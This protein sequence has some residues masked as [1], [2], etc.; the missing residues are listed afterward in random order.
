MIFVFPL[1]A[2]YKFTMGLPATITG[3]DMLL[4]TISEIVIFLSVVFV[5]F[6]CW[7]SDEKNELL[8]VDIVGHGEHAKQSHICFF[9]EFGAEVNDIFDPNTSD[10]EFFD[11]LTSCSDAV[12]IASPDKFHPE[13]LLQLVNVGKHVLV[14]KPI[15]IDAPGKKLVEEAVEIAKQKN[16]VILTCHPRR[17]DPPVGW[18]KN[19]IQQCVVLHGKLVKFTFEF[20][21]HKVTDLWKMDRSLLQD[22]LCHEIDLLNFFFGTQSLKTCTKGYDS[23]FHYQVD[24][25]LN[26]G[27]LFEFKGQRA[28]NDNKYYEFIYLD[29][30]DGT[31]MNVNLNDG[32]LH[33]DFGGSCNTT[34]IPKKDYDVMFKA[35]NKNWFNSIY[36]ISEPYL[37]TEEMMFNQTVSSAVS[38][39]GTWPLKVQ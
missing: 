13:Q 26:D 2:Y 7:N 5:N 20:M 22:H 37:T 32:I 8:S 21:Y 39:H 38:E 27:T 10:L 24:G 16:L 18:L 33:G 1:F 11:I 9:K 19:N 17:F 31:R 23:Y 15:F 35:V 12:I 36:G 3:Q 6:V 30:E 28:L 29:F 25:E 4:M 34:N 14:E